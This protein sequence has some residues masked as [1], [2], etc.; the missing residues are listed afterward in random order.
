MRF[1]VGIASAC[2][3]SIVLAQGEVAGVDIGRDCG[4]YAVG[5]VL[6]L[7]GH[8]VPAFDE[9]KRASRIQPDGTTSL[10]AVASALEDYGVTVRACVLTS[11]PPSI[12]TVAHAHD[13]PDDLP[14]RHFVVI[15][16]GTDDEVTVCSPPL[17]V[18]TMRWADVLPLLTP[19][20]IECP[21]EPDTTGAVVVVALG[22]T[23]CCAVYL[24]YRRRAQS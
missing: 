18:R 1:S 6:R 8:A 16:P 21:T 11:T 22:S 2:L 4:A 17:W 24:L 23:F 14:T 13:S 19:R 5:L 12:L 3:V 20:A 7:K 9:L 10:L 15:V